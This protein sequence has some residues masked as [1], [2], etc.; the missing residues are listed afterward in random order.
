MPAQDR[1]LTA[2]AG[3][4]PDLAGTQMRQV[5]GDARGMGIECRWKKR[6]R[7]PVSFSSSIQ[8]LEDTVAGDDPEPTET[9]V[10]A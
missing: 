9:E 7:L 6:G 2:A 1:V 5:L 8:L 10:P 4:A 3:Q